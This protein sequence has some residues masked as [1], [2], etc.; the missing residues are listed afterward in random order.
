MTTSWLISIFGLTILIRTFDRLIKVRRINQKTRRDVT[1]ILIFA[2][3]TLLVLLGKHPKYLWWV[4]ISMIAAPLAAVWLIERL[5]IKSFEAQILNYLDNMLLEMRL[6]KGFA[7]A[8]SSVAKREQTTSGFYLR[9]IASG[10]TFNQDSANLGSKSLVFR[11]YGEFLSI[12]RAQ[13]RAI[14][15]VKSLRAQLKREQDF[16]RRAAQAMLQTRAQAFVVTLLYLA[17]FSF[18]WISGGGRFDIRILLGSIVLFGSGLLW[19]LRT[20]RTI[21]WKT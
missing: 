8:L 1:G 14:E 3:F 16:R 19:I 7:E 6:G 2:Q 5:Q 15:R 11:I 4:E 17:L 9:E 21:K 12:K 13:F 18:T 20:G 10:L